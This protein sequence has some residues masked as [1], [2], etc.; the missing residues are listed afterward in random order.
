MDILDRSNLHLNIDR[1]DWVRAESIDVLIGRGSHL[2]SFLAWIV[3]KGESFLIA[4]DGDGAFFIVALGAMHWFIQDVLGENFN[5][6]FAQ[7]LVITPE[8]IDADS[9]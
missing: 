2:E 1:Y 8:G 7:D 4:N 3:S 6:S 5:E 9:R